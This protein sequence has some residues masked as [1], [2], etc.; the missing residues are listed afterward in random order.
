MDY[1]WE[2]VRL[3]CCRCP[4]R[5]YCDENTIDCVA[6]MVIY[7]L[8]EVGKITPEDIEDIVELKLLWSMSE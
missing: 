8:L 5:D 3:L 1:H 7:R 2:L 4:L 6:Y